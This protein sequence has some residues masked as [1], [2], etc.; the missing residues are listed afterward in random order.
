[1]EGRLTTVLRRTKTS[2]P[3]RRIKELPVAISEH[4]YFLRSAWLGVGF[5]LLRTHANYKRDY[6]LPRLNQDG[7]LEK[8]PASYADAMVATAGLLSIL[9]L[10]LEVQGYW[11]EHSERSVLPT[12]LSL[13]E[14]PPLGR[15]KPEGSDTYARTFAGRVARLQALFAKVARGADRYD[16]LDEREIAADLF[17]WLMEQR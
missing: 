11:T 13:M 17:P 14:V 7:L 15:W 2:G 8:K 10:P 1:M 12:G 4:A 16:R 3:S 9:G 5:D 6:L